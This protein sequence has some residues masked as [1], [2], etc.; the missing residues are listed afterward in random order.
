MYLKKLK[1]Y[2]LKTLHAHSY[3]TNS[4]NGTS[5]CCLQHKVTVLKSCFLKM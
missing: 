4:V 1:V 3:N 2:I 5:M